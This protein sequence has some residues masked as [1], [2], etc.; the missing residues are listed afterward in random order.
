[1]VGE[2]VRSRSAKL[3]GEFVSGLGDVEG[4]H[5]EVVALIQALHQKG[6]LDSKNLLQSLAEQRKEWEHAETP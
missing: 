1:M 5:K 3:I 6:R 4:L 2:P